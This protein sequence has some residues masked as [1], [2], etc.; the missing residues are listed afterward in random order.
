MQC[1]KCRHAVSQQKLMAIFCFVSNKLTVQIK[2]QDQ[3]LTAQFTLTQLLLK[4]RIVSQ[5]AASNC[6]QFLK[7]YRGSMSNS[8]M[9][10][11]R[12]EGH[13]LLS[14]SFCLLLAQLVL[15]SVQLQSTYLLSLATLIQVNVCGLDAVA[16]KKQLIFRKIETNKSMD[17]SRNKKRRQMES[18][19]IKKTLIKFKQLEFSI[20]YSFI[21]IKSIYKYYSNNE[22]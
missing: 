2:R 7:A 15:Q 10:S 13:Y 5:N 11:I 1:G 9:T 4:S 21:L 20:L 16:V 14:K 18:L 19:L 8:V 12:P 6:L 17:L 3:E 22:K